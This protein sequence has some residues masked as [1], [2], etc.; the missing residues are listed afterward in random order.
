MRVSHSTTRPFFESISRLSCRTFFWFRILNRVPCH[1]PM[2]IA[3]QRPMLLSSYYILL[4]SL[5]TKLIS[6]FFIRHLEILKRLFHFWSFLGTSYRIFYY[7]NFYAPPQNQCKKAFCP[8]LFL[9]TSS[10]WRNLSNSRF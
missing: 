3:D 6:T 8:I 5:G 7:L 10:A 1:R 2:R 9:T 4:D